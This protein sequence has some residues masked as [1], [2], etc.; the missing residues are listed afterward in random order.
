MN[1]DK[2]PTLRG[3]QIRNRYVKMREHEPC[4]GVIRAVKTPPRSVEQSEKEAWSSRLKSKSAKPR[5]GPAAGAK[6]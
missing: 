4:R 1:E 6:A 3:R 5:P 2:A